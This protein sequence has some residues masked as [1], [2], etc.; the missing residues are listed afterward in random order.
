MAKNKLQTETLP[1]D[2]VNKF[3]NSNAT[4]TELRTGIW[5][6]IEKISS[7][8]ITHLSFKEN[9]NRRSVETSWGRVVVKGCILTQTHRDLLD[10]II[11]ESTKGA[12]DAYGSVALYFKQERVLKRYFG[13]GEGTNHKWLRSKLDEIQQ[14][15]IEIRTIGTDDEYIDSSFNILAGYSFS[16]KEKAFFIKFSPEYRNYFENNLSVTYGS[17]LDKLL[18]I[19]SPLIRSI[20]RFFWTHEVGSHLKIPDLLKTIGYPI[21]SPRSVRTAKKDIK[22][23]IDILL[24]AGISES[25]GILNYNKKSFSN[26]ISFIS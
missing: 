14:A 23:N 6:P 26:S 7:K 10:C 16:S 11:E 12:Q 17:E 25:N 20:V 24:E 1:L 19:K 2:I 22:D 4:V 9:G 13:G 3:E 5:A 18:R 8:S 15:S 21:D